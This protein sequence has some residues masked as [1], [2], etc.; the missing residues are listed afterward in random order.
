[1]KK[2]IIVVGILIFISYFL[3]PSEYKAKAR[4]KAGERAK[5]LWIGRMHISGFNAKKEV[6][7]GPLEGFDIGFREDGVVVWRKV[8]VEVGGKKKE[9]KEGVKGKE[10]K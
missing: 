5:V 9:V 2:R 8:N 6:V 4:E 3:L 1:M 10:G 7:S